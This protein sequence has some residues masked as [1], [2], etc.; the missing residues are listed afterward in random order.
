[1][2]LYDLQYQNFIR[3]K[4]IVNHQIKVNNL[5]EEGDVYD[6]LQLLPLIL[7]SLGLID[8]YQHKELI[9]ALDSDTKI[10]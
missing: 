4:E 3:L 5:L 8:Y 1:M 7:V 6:G 9:E 2:L 10:K